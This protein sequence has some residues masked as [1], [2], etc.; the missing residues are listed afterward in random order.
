MAWT[1]QD[2]IDTETQIRALRDAGV[3]RVSISN[4]SADALKLES[5]LALRA[6]IKGELAA[7]NPNGLGGPRFRKTIPPAAG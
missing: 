2:L 1:T 6:E 3:Q 4:H 5:L 7:A